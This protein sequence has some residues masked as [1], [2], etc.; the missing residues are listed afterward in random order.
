MI[1]QEQHDQMVSIVE[2]RHSVIDP[3][4]TTP[5]EYWELVQKQTLHQLGGVLTNYAQTLISIVGTQLAELTIFRELETEL[6]RDS[7][8][9]EGLQDIFARLKQLRLA[10]IPPISGSNDN[11]E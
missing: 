1:S 2:N 8:T 10:S 3:T 11:Q 4:T 6:V 7:I 5:R 9:P